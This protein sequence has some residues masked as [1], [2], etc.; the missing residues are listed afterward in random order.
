MSL[1]R[2]VLPVLLPVL[3]VLAWGAGTAQA[4]LF[5]A[6]PNENA[7]GRL[8]SD[9]GNVQPLWLKGIEEPKAVATDG[10]DVYWASHEGVTKTTVGSVGFDGQGF[11]AS[12]FKADLAPAD[13]AIGGGHLFLDGDASVACLHVG[14]VESPDNAAQLQ[15]A[16]TSEGTDIET[17]VE[18]QCIVWGGAAVSH[19]SAYW[20]DQGYE[21]WEGNEEPSIHQTTVG[22]GTS[23]IVIGAADLDEP[24]GLAAD[25][26]HLYWADTHGIGR[27]TFK[28]DG[29]VEAINPNFVTGLHGPAY[30]AVDG[31]YVYWVAPG[32]REYAVFRA[33]KQ[34]GGGV[35]ELTTI[36]DTHNLFEGNIPFGLAASEPEAH[37]YMA[38]EALSFGSRQVGAVPGQP[39]IDTLINDGELALSASST[40]IT[41]PD[42]G[43]FKVE[44]ACGQQVPPKGGC[45]VVVKFQPQA[46]GKRTATL[47]VANNAVESPFH[48]ALSGVGLGPAIAITPT[49]WNFGPQK[50][51]GG[52]TPPRGFA[53]ENVGNEPMQVDEVSLGDEADFVFE[54]EPEADCGEAKI[55]PGHSCTVEISFDPASTGTK[56]TTL[57]VGAEAP[58]APATATALL[59]GTGTKPALTISPE[60]VSFPS[61]GVGNTSGPQ[62][63]TI[64]NSGTAPL[65]VKGVSASGSTANQFHVT[66][67]CGVL[68]PGASCQAEVSFEPTAVGTKLDHLQV[69]TDY[70]GTN[71]TTTL[72]GT[73]VSPEA[74][75]TP[76]EVAFG[77]R[78]LG[79]GA[80]AV[81]S[82]AFK[83][84]GSEELEVEGVALG[85]EDPGQFEL[86]AGG[87]GC[88]GAD[89]EP[90]DECTVE[91]AFDPSSEGPQTAK[92][93]IDDDVFADPHT[94][95]LEGTG[96]TPRISVTPSAL[97][98][99]ALLP[100]NGSKQSFT[101]GNPGS[102]P[103]TVSSVDLGGPGAASY[104]VDASACLAAPIP[105]ETEAG[106]TVDVGFSPGATG[107]LE[108]TLTVASDAASG[109]DAVA[110]SGSGCPQLTAS[111]SAQTPTR[112]FA[113]GV[114][115]AASAPA[116]VTLNATLR[117]HAAGK[118]RSVSLGT[119]TAASGGSVS[120]A[121]PARLRKWIEPGQKVNLLLQG[122]ATPRGVAGCG[123]QAVLDQALPVKAGG[124]PK[125]RH[126]HHRR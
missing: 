22:G 11:R 103:L 91:V 62:P 124:H 41:G 108:A 17:M 121:L 29:S 89:L 55:A 74:S 1:R 83:S 84:T 35:R 19:D 23:R 75:L 65:E 27:A 64:S 20:I 82:F 87:D 18:S 106:C 36:P 6:N 119:A 32:A 88:S 96:T 58:A 114:A 76:G 5:F 48:V 14:E 12:I 13:L 71:A 77:S 25:E 113:V 122:E 54:S 24:A 43:D 109:P 110:L 15:T 56:T 34:T 118:A 37:A 31:H 67:A 61:T 26:E 86:V 3:A 94:A 59:G 42:A 52:A 39:Q 117:F 69:L 38:Q 93:E 16:T 47:T 7:I 66:S 107:A 30:P 99:P 49:E 126:R 95:L 44:N 90:G 33:D 100:G 2:L 70:F 46:P 9:G 102:G 111:A 115:L 60:T 21:L 10:T 85:G 63:V 73:A 81:T 98:F 125:R 40:E 105:A 68:A 57:K 45:G 123:A 53:I 79:S 28:P 51:K 116:T 120:F 50:V 72:R 78:N 4:Y 92:L 104:S 101:I 112:R 97:T 80:G 8:D